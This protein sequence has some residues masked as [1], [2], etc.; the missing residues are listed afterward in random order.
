MDHSR[1]AWLSGLIRKHARVDER[2]MAAFVP[3]HSGS[4]QRAH[5]PTTRT[6]CRTSRSLWRCLS[7]RGDF[8][9]ST[10]CVFNCEAKFPL[11]RGE[12]HYRNSGAR[13]SRMTGKFDTTARG[14][15]RQVAFFGTSVAGVGTDV[16]SEQF[17]NTR[18]L[19]ECIG[20]CVFLRKT[21]PCCVLSVYTN[22][23]TALAAKGAHKAKAPLPMEWRLGF[24]TGHWP[25]GTSTVDL[26]HLL[27]MPSQLSL[28]GGRSFG[29][30]S[31]RALRALALPML[32]PGSPVTSLAPSN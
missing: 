13:V 14:R 32:I 20:R 22:S 19:F 4:W 12:L 6:V 27:H 24:C 10:W 29:G 26:V 3:L 30:G 21:H 31:C 15:K 2:D 28:V 1:S 8:A 23:E 9:A 25:L 16:A 18:R 7:K 5:A 11:F 17:R